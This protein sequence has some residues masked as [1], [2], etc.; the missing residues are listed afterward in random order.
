LSG[1]TRRA[2]SLSSRHHA[3]EFRCV[4]EL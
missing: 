4:E 1:L 3:E 2:I